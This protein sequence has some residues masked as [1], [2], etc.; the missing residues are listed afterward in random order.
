MN[1]VDPLHLRHPRRWLAALLLAASAGVASAQ[2]PRAEIKLSLGV[3]GWTGYAPL[4][5][6][7][8]AGLFKKHGLDVTIKRIPQGTRH[9]AVAAGEVQ[10]AGH[11]VEG[12]L[13][14]ADRGLSMRQIFL[15]DKSHGADGIVVKPSIQK[16]GDLKGK[17]IGV[18]A[19]GT[20]PYFLLAHLLKKNGLS[21]RDVNVVSLEPQ[22][23][24]NAFVAG[25]A[26]F[27][28][29]M[30]YEPYLS[31]VRGRPDAGRIL[32]TTVDYPVVMDSIG[33]TTQFLSAHPRAGK[34][35]A[36]AYFDA[37]AL[38]KADPRRSFEIMGAAAKQSAEAFE[39]SQ[40]FLRW[41]DR[42]ANQ[43]FFATEHAAFMKEAAELLLEV[44]LIQ[45]MP[46]LNALADTR[47]IRP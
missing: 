45:R 26:E 39:R 13:I 46:D 9:L 47:Y 35:L 20:S 41:Q 40:S 8:E 34:A 21:L 31:S 7:K 44:G 19:P 22:A 25:S 24:A 28:A 43:K 11:T 29:A 15:L 33:C 16:F 23:A 6:A 37:L 3:S 30:T 42:A 17:T 12:W 14:W 5:L 27:D 36:D 10:C 2:E 1:Q 4:T 18:G 32:A 38:M